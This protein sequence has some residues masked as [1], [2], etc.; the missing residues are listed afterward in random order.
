MSVEK[1][2][3]ERMPARST[4]HKKKSW[5]L[6]FKIPPFIL[7]ENILTGETIS[8]E[9]IKVRNNMIDQENVKFWISPVEVSSYTIATEAQ[10][11]PFGGEG[12]PLKS[13]VWSVE[14]LNLASLRAAQITLINAMYFKL[15]REEGN[16]SSSILK[17]IT[18]GASPNEITSASESSCLP[19]SPEIPMARATAPSNKSRSAA[20]KINRGQNS[21]LFD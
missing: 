13:V 7:N 12:I 2:T 19:S 20:I 14:I 18:D 9:T 5:S 15:S 17:A 3:N 16:S 8:N 11:I 6:L 1:S 4:V 10:K 21:K